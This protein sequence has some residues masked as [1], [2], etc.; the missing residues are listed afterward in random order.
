M[1]VAAIST[2]PL[3]QG[4]A[5]ILSMIILCAE[6]SVWEWCTHLLVCA[7]QTAYKDEDGSV[8]MISM[9]V[10]MEYFDKKDFKA[11]ML[12]C[13]AD[14]VSCGIPTNEVNGNARI[15]PTASLGKTNATLTVQYDIVA[16]SFNWTLFKMDGL[17]P[18]EVRCMHRVPCP[19]FGCYR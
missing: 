15:D 13:K 1:R 17:R 14:P 2:T 16:D 12:K 4:V 3:K 8:G 6:C 11:V 9:S 18:M 5:L 19:F 7:L 10:E